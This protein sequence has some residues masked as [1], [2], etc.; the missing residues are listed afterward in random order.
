[1]AAGRASSWFA[2]VAAAL[3]VHGGAA[4]AP[5][6]RVVSINLCADQLA[7]ALLP[8]ERL[9]SLSPL[10]GDPD[11]SYVAPHVGGLP[12]NRGGAEEVLA[13]KPDLVLAGRE[14]ARQS[15]GIL[16]RLGIEVFDV[17]APT[18][19]S[20]IV[21]EIRRVA[22]R[23]ET[24][25][26]GEDLIAGMRASLASARSRRP[27]PTPRAAY[28]Y[29]NGFTAGAGTLP[30]AVLQ[31][32]GW[33]NAAADAGLQGYG[34]LGLENLIAAKPDLLVLQ[35]ARHEA[36]SLAAGMLAHPALA[37]ALASVPRLT[38]PTPLLI[39]A[40]PHTAEAVRRLAA[41]R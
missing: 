24:E 31:A 9:I 18:S 23:L 1:M 19:F 39:C 36:P 40:G 10:A 20:G 4:A 34:N 8:R 11:L 13:L 15:A 25:A 33:R 14:A 41:A 29:P 5:P 30:D 21:D 22:A 16:R 3:L 27:H 2:A 28:Y 38:L 17:A 6:T 35:V 37:R 12:R 32:A 7:V 26:R